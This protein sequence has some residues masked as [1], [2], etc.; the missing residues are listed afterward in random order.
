MLLF[1]RVPFSNYEK[2]LFVIFK[3]I[4]FDQANAGTSCEIQWGSE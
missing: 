1:E 4:I 3:F 2:V